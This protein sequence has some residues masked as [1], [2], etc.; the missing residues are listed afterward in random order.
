VGADRGF[1]SGFFGFY[2]HKKHLSLRVSGVDT[3][4]VGCVGGVDEGFGLAEAV[5]EE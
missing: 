2:G 1:S 3:K 4:T 5:P